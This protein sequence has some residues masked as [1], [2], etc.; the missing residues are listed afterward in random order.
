VELLA[1]RVA[2]QSSATQG[3]RAIVRNRAWQASVIRAVVSAF[4][5]LFAVSSVPPVMSYFAGPR[6]LSL[7]ELAA[8]PAGSYVTTAGGVMVPVFTRIITTT[9]TRR[10]ASPGAS[11]VRTSESLDASYYLL[12]SRDG[13]RLL[14][15][16]T[17]GAA[18]I[19][20]GVTGLMRPPSN[21][22]RAEVVKILTEDGNADLVSGVLP[23]RLDVT[24][25]GPVDLLLMAIFLIAALSSL[26]WLA[27]TVRWT[28]N[29][30]SHPATQQL[31]HSGVAQ[32]LDDDLANPDRH[33]ALPGLILTPSAFIE[34]G[35]LSR[36]VRI[37][38]PSQLIWAYQEVR[39]IRW[40]VT[41]SLVLGLR[42]GRKVSN[43]ISG[44]T[45]PQSVELWMRGH[46]PWVPFG[47][48][49]E[50]ADLYAKKR[51]DFIRAVDQNRVAGGPQA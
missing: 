44:A 15:V 42:S 32:A 35:R 49:S 33:L 10:G 19:A 1:S 17:K 13:E 3:F 47:Y 21:E 30:A 25:Y 45:N 20:S 36:T 50:L 41:K 27:R 16:K 26:V 39:Q 31:L 23:M 14:L 38:P 4:L 18:P 11:P 37:L 40:R 6:T 22:E 46:F 34:L 5:L 7:D 9:T 2:E 29:P 51:A 48:S 43:G 12:Q 24:R 28:I 8:A